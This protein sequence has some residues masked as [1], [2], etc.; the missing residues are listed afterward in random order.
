MVEKMNEAKMLKDLYFQDAQGYDRVPI[1]KAVLSKQ[2]LLNDLEL[3]EDS[4]KT[5]ASLIDELIQRAEYIRSADTVCLK[6]SN[7]DNVEEWRRTASGYTNAIKKCMHGL[8]AQA[9]TIG[10]MFETVRK[11]QSVLEVDM[12]NQVENYVANRASSKLDFTMIDAINHLSALNDIC[13]DIASRVVDELGRNTKYTKEK[14]ETVVR[15]EKVFDILSNTV[16]RLMTYYKNYL[17]TIQELGRTGD[18]SIASHSAEI[19][20]IIQR[21]NLNEMYYKE[22]DTKRLYEIPEINR[23][24]ILVDSLSETSIINHSDIYHEIDDT[25]VDI[26]RILKIMKED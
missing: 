18:L 8:A 6:P 19:K 24:M 25:L 13:I 12:C 2:A 3:C 1:A 15:G 20:L 11:L 23:L 4:V 26:I 7:P 17:N 5:D 21:L 14:V 16:T 9:E 10:D 22:N